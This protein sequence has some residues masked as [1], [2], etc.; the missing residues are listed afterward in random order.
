MRT[1]SYVGL[2]RVLSPGSW[3]VR[4][5]DLPGCEAV[6]KNFKEVFD[7][8]RIA[9]TEELAELA[10][11]EPRPRS[12]AELLI[13]ARRDPALAGELARSVMHPVKPAESTDLAPIELVAARVKGGGEDS[14]QVGG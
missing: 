4:F 11:R 2:F 9:L 14:P 8:A 3:R 10:G 6:G 1:S 7:G 13:D 12:T 5:P